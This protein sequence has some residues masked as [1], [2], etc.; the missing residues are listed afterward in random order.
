MLRFSFVVGPN[1]IFILCQKKK[2]QQQQW[3]Q[4]SVL[5]LPRMK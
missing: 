1:F 5:K 3:L 4:A 2:K